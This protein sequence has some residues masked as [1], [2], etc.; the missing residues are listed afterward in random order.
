MNDIEKTSWEDIESGA[1]EDIEKVA[2][3][4]LWIVSRFSFC[5]IP[6]LLWRLLLR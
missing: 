3:K 2:W 1:W 4:I 5:R 6:L